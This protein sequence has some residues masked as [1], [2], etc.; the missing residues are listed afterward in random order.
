MNNFRQNADI[1]GLAANRRAEK[2]L[3]VALAVAVGLCLGFTLV[4]WWTA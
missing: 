2:I 4:A 3:D 1:R